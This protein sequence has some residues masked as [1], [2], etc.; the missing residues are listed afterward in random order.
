MEEESSH[1][2]GLFCEEP[3]SVCLS[4]E[5]LQLV[6]SA[7]VECDEFSGVLFQKV[8]RSHQPGNRETSNSLAPHGFRYLVTGG[9][10]IGFA[11]IYVKL[12]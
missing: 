2:S 4:A 3:W 10:E 6:G 9:H 1:C 11:D 5:S 8:D 12:L 7:A